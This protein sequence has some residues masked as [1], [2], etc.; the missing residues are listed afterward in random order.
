M[1]FKESEAFVFPQSFS[2]KVC[3]NT[4]AIVLILV[5]LHRYFCATFFKKVVDIGSKITDF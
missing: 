2:R 1:L 4:T 3:I 5:G